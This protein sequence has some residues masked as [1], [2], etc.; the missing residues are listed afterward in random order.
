MGFVSYEELAVDNKIQENIR[1]H[2]RLKNMSIDDFVKELNF[3][4][5]F[6]TI[7]PSFMYGSRLNYFEDLFVIVKLRMKELNDNGYYSFS[8]SVYLNKSTEVI[9][10]FEKKV[11]FLNEFK[12]SYLILKHKYLD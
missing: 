4:N 3:N 8:K 10:V 5:S 11:N 6:A 12:K 2:V 1:N 7:Y 9:Y